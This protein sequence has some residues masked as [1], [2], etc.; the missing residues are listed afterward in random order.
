MS[1]PGTVVS[2]INLKD[3]LI[4]DEMA[5]GIKVALHLIAGSCAELGNLLPRC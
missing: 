2:R 5:S 1:K 4:T 3:D